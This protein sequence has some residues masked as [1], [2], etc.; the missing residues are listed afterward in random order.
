MSNITIND[1][2]VGQKVYIEL[3]GNAK[4]GK[5]P[6]DL[7]VEA[8]VE[9]IGKKYVTVKG[10][11]FK[12]HDFSYGG[13]IQNTNTCIDYVLYPDKKA[14]EDKLQSEFLIK[15]IN[16]RISRLSLGGWKAISLDSLKKIYEILNEE[17]V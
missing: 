3:T 1:F 17:N 11:Q 14:L 9:K 7:I 6:E 2:K 15:D 10:Y 4:R 13:L 8:V 16:T 5:K 12:E